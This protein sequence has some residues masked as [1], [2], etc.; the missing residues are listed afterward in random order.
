[1][2]T[3]QYMRGHIRK[4]VLLIVLAFSAV[5]TQACG[6]TLEYENFEHIRDWDTDFPTIVE[7]EDGIFLLYYYAVWCPACAEIK[8]DVLQFADDSPRGYNTY[9]IDINNIQG[10]W[11]FEPSGSG[12][13][14]MFVIDEGELVD[15][16]VGYIDIPAL[17]NEIRSGD[18]AP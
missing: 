8:E 2:D 5:M 1:M 17:M 18:Y 11:P 4:V 6:R 13:P 7:K 15:E 10:E 12:I 14:R 3:Q 16:A 9:L